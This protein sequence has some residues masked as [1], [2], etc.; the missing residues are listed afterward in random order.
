M[1][2]RGIRSIL[3]EWRAAERELDAATDDDIREY[4]HARIA[5]LHAEHH[6]ALGKRFEEADVVG[7]LVPQFPP[8]EDS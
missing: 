1:E 7:H 6:A 8:A 2:R 5:A 3:E 4:L